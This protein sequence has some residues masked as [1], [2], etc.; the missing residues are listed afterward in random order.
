MW[1]KYIEDPKQLTPKD[2]HL[3]V[4]K[5]KPSTPRRRTQMCKE[6]QLSLL[7]SPV[8]VPSE[9]DF[10]Q[11]FDT[12]QEEAKEVD[13]EDT[14]TMTDTSDSQ[15]VSSKQ[16]SPLQQQITQSDAKSQISNISKP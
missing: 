13:K 8:K 9:K 4:L 3:D 10:S 2:N 14:I 6:I 1:D 7:D 11:S 15:K 12:V 16:G 5:P